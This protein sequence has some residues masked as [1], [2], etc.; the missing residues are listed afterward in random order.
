MKPEYDLENMRPADQT[1][2]R[3]LL[4]RDK[5]RAVLV[6]FEE[7]TE[8]EVQAFWQTHEVG[9]GLLAEPLDAA[10]KAKLQ[11]ARDARK[12]R[13]ITMNLSTNLEQRLRVL[14]ERKHTPYQTLL[15]EFVLERVYEEEKRLGILEGG[16]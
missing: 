3:E 10:L 4:A 7:M 14:A 15:K 13:N 2:H 5:N 8:T 6:Q 1:R 11:A 16:A 9:E 12:S